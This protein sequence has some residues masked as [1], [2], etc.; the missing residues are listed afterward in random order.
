MLTSRKKSNII[1]EHQ[2]HQTDTGSAEVQ[3]ALTSRRIDELASH[4]KKHPK[5]RHSRKGLLGMVNRRRKL[6]RYLS[7][8][9]PTSYKKVV[10]K[11]GLKSK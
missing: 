6:L 5:D 11:L 3:V 10:K 9:A 4:L 1:K 7:E 2:L 8:K